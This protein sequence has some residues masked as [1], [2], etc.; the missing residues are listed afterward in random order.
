MKISK[1]QLS[2][3]VEAYLL[4][5]E[6]T[7]TKGIVYHGSHLEPKKFINLLKAG[8]IGPQEGS[9]N[10]FGYGL[11]TFYNYDDANQYGNYLYK[12]EVD[13]KGYICFTED[14]CK[15]IYGKLLTPLQ[16]LMECAKAYPHNKNK[17]KEMIEFMIKEDKESNYNFLNRPIKN[18]DEADV[19]N[20]NS[21]ANFVVPGIIFEDREGPNCLVHDSRT[22]VLLA[23]QESKDPR[24]SEGK[25]DY[26][27][28]EDRI[29]FVKD[30][31]GNPVYEILPAI[32]RL[33]IPEDKV[34]KQRKV[35]NFIPNPDFVR[36]YIPDSLPPKFNPESDQY[37]Q[38]FVNRN[39]GMIDA[40]AT[41]LKRKK[42]DVN[43]MSRWVNINDIDRSPSQRVSNPSTAQGSD[44]K[45]RAFGKRKHLKRKEMPQRFIPKRK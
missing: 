23:Y 22:V 11:Y 40:L 2:R 10:A 29:E 27:R 32:P 25:F 45:L 7:G 26:L 33:G 20:F 43:D 3:L 24:D 18:Y 30:E 9:V 6:I 37:D 5:E 42:F 13:L 39:I 36:N 14:A 16:Q 38:D 4:K 1:K 34:P 41:S 44:L 28:T 15:Q 19:Q 17:I 35:V 31:N 12:L 21:Y 8:K